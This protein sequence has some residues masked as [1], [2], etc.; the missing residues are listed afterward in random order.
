MRT[1]ARLAEGPAAGVAAGDPEDDP[2][3]CTGAGAGRGLRPPGG[4]PSL[5]RGG[6]LPYGF[7]ADEG[8]RGP[9][10]LS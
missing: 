9:R 10:G 3:D 5:F 7:L 8:A 1:V 6:G 2:S 4:G